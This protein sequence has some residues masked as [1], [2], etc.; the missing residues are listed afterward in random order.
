MLMNEIR[1]KDE[2]MKTNAGI[3]KTGNKQLL[4]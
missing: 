4:K 2:A 1:R 3:K